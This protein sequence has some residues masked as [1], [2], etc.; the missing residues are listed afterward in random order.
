M[1]K[2][3]MKPLTVLGTTLMALAAAAAV[4]AVMAQTDTQ[5]K[6]PPNPWADKSDAE[7]QADVDAAHKRNDE[8]LLAFVASKQD[9]RAL[10][11][12]E[13]E[14]YAAPL[15]D[16]PSSVAAA[17]LIVRVVVE[18]TTFQINPSGGL[19]IALST[20]RVA[21]VDKGAPGGDVIVVRQLGG[22]VAQPNGGALARLDNDESILPGD[23]VVLFLQRASDGRYT[24]Q[25]GTGVYFVRDGRAY[26][27]EANP[28]GGQMSGLSVAEVTESIAAAVE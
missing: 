18:G 6:F 13:I 1:I 8:Y 28:F 7:R 15:A 4:A 17:D 2:Q 22:P 12:I 21:S 25:P 11:V 10:A 20:V 9:P 24:T 19:P 23:D 16:L 14:A 26:A 5:P 3:T 27:E